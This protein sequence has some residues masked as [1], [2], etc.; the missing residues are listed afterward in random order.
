MA[1]NPKNAAAQR[2]WRKTARG[3]AYMRKYNKETVDDRVERNAAHRKAVKKYGKSKMKGKSVHHKN[4]NPQDNSDSNLAV[5]R[6]Y[7][8]RQPKK[9]S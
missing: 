5:A 6:R 4:G 2:K 7:H 1:D 9:N 8:G 3:R